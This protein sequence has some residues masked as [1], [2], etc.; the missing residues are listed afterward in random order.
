VNRN[1]IVMRASPDWLNF[2][3]EESRPFCRRLR[4]RE[5]LII[6]F[7]ERWRRTFGISYGE[8]RHELKAITLGAIAATRDCRL[9][10]AADLDDPA[11]DDLFVFI[12][13]DDWSAPHLFE[14]LRSMETPSDG[15]FWGSV[16]LGKFLVDAPGY[17]GGGAP[18]WARP[19]CRSAPCKTSSTPTI[20]R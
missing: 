19:S 20:T 12:D 14:A 6:E 9:G 5:D 1:Y 18:R 13:D 15:W 7:A 3:L 10:G 2:D 16:F 17:A 8:I 11:D 4:L